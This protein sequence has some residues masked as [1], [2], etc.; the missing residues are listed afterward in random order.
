MGSRLLRTIAIVVLTWGLV[1]VIGAVLAGPTRFAVWV[2]RTLAPVLNAEPLWV[3]GGAAFLYVILLLWAPFAAFQ[4][5]LSSVGL[6]IV[7]AVGIWLLRRRTLAEFPDAD[8]GEHAHA[9]R[10]RVGKVWGSVTGAVSS[11]GSGRHKGSDAGGHTDQLERLA[12]LHE[13]GAL[14]DE[15]FATAKAKLLA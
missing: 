7:F 2:R 13:T 6:A 11:I 3:F 14:S 10:E 8:L 12:R 4:T 9:G 1:L 15:E 5:V